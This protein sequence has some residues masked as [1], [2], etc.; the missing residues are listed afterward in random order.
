MGRWPAP[1]LGAK[2]TILSQG[3]NHFLRKITEINNSETLPP[4]TL[5]V[6]WDVKSLYTNITNENGMRACEHYMSV[7]NYDEYKRTTVLKFI[8]LVLTCN[9]LTFQGS[10]Y[11]QQIGTAMGT[12]MAPTYANLYM[13]LLEEQLLEQT[14]L[15]P[16]VWFRFI[17][18]IFSSGLWVQLN[19]S[20]SLMY[21]TVLIHTL[22]LSKRYLQPPFPFWMYK[23]S[24]ITAR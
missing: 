9:N 22:N 19:S 20:S 5:L 1:A 18:D 17:D 8:Q 24:L 21:V 4:D 13:G 10:H 14:T 16:L 7:N 15:K 3:D 11:T 6:A 2:I 12:R 23:W